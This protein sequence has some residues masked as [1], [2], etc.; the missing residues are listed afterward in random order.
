MDHRDPGAPGRSEPRV[1]LPLHV[2]ATAF[3]WQVWQGPGTIP[4]GETRAYGEIAAAIGRPTAVRSVARA[5]A[6]NPVNR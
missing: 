6:T 1:D 4:H 3:Q 2:Q 5:C